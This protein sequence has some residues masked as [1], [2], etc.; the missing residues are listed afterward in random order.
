MGRIRQ[1]VARRVRASDNMVLTAPSAA[2]PTTLWYRDRY[3]DNVRPIWQV[4]SQP[5]RSAC[6]Q[7][8][9]RKF[10]QHPQYA[11]MSSVKWEVA[12]CGMDSTRTT[13]RPLGLY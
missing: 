1:L 10:P 9:D 7:N 6:E 5:S 2:T 13:Q 4:W 11:H 12:M 8:L 3:G